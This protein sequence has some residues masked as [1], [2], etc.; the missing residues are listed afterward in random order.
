MLAY[1]GA[2]FRTDRPAAEDSGAYYMP[3]QVA[4][5]AECA[6]WLRERRPATDGRLKP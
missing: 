3:A 4:A 5:W 1:A 2:N 6:K